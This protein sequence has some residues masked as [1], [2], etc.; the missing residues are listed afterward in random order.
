LP[1]I[2]GRLKRKGYISPAPPKDAPKEIKEYMADTYAGLRKSKFPG[3]K[4]ENKARAAKLTWY[5]TKR[6]YPDY[7]KDHTHH[8]RD[9]VSD[10]RHP[11]ILKPVQ[12]KPA[13]TA[14]GRRKQIGQLNRA[15][16]R[17]HGYAWTAQNE[18]QSEMALSKKKEGVESEDLKRDAIV[19]KGFSKDR[20]T[21]AHDYELQAARIAMIEGK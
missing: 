17:E 21:L 18:F 12:V 1:D 2:P 20:D 14:A 16:K 7:F 9:P 13:R 11:K 3:E 10:R 8:S 19:A 6:K 15:A 4:K 5:L